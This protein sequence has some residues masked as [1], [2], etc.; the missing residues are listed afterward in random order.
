[1]LQVTPFHFISYVTS[2]NTE[3]EMA[4]KF[5]T[6]TWQKHFQLFSLIWKILF[7]KTPVLTNSVLDPT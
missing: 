6:P 7:L 3:Y 5:S 2:L 1:M 4:F